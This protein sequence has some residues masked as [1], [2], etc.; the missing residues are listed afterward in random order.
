MRTPQ[1]GPERRFSTPGEL[2]MTD[3]QAVSRLD[4]ASVI[5]PATQLKDFASGKL[6]DPTIVTSGKGI[7]IEDAQG[8]T[9]ICLL[10]TSPSPRD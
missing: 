6:N 2:A 8:R 5:H 1:T 4:R 9:Y 7:R 10:Y 3:I